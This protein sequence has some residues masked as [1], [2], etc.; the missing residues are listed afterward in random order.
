MAF[1]SGEHVSAGSP[2]I[3]FLHLLR[4]KALRLVEWGLLPAECPSC[5]PSISV[6]LLNGTQSTDPNHS[7]GFNLSSFTTGLLKK[8]ALHTLHQLSD[9]SITNTHRTDSMELPELL[10]C[11][12]T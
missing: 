10:Q 8:G 2:Q 12:C 11:Y 5:H 4:N 7:P 3:P 1:T 6:K 9:A